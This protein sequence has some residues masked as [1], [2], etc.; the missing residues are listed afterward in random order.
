MQSGE[1]EDAFRRN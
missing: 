1:S